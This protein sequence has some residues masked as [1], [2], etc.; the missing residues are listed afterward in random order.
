HHLAVDL[1][2]DEARRCHGAWVLDTQTGAVIEARAPATLLA[3]GGCGQVFLHTTNPR[4]ASGDGVAMAWRAGAGVG[5]MEF[6][7]FHPTMLYDPDGPSFLVSEALRGYGA[8]LVNGRGE[9]FTESLKTRDVVSRAI[10]AQMQESGAE[11]VYL[12][13]TAQDAE[14]TRRRFPNI[15]RHCLGIGIDMT[16][17]SIPVVPAAHYMCGGV[18]T[19]AYGQ[20]D[21][22]GL[23][24]AGEV[25]MSGFQGAN[26]LASNSLLE[27]LVFAR[28]AA[29]HARPDP[30]EFAGVAGAQPTAV[31]S[32]VDDL[33]E[34]RQA[35]RRLMWEEVG[36]VRNGR[37]L[38]RARVETERM[39]GEI[40]ALCD[41]LA[42]EAERVQLRN[43]ATV[44]ELIARSARQRL[45]SRGT[46][47]N[48][49]YPE[50]DD[51]RWQRPTLLVGHQ[52]VH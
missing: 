31:A 12:D 38:E 15:Y 41:G 8:V 48:S 43:L 5:N 1:I 52:A 2:V 17:E 21:L 47:Y 4:V 24:A 16:K 37:G 46:H 30:V 14:T 36:I 26:R 50:R 7:Q 51:A 18:C 23:Y 34:R 22:A 10:V 49:D 33:E 25:A 3:T 44:A 11:C 32:A 6:T 28:R 20:T 39:A 45:E 13:A 27:G 35:L 42:P 9:A 40:E 19:D 29:A